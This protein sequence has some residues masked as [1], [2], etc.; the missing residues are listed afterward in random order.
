MAFIIG[1][2]NVLSFASYEDVVATDQRL[3]Q[4]NEG[5]TGDEGVELVE[6]DLFRATERIL[7]QIRATGWWVNYYSIQSGGSFDNPADVP[8]V[9]PNLIQDR[10]ADFTDLC[11]FEAL[12]YYI[13]PGVADFGDGDAGGDAAFEKIDYYKIKSGGLLDE[14]ILAGDWYD[15]DNDGIIQSSEKEPAI[16]L[17][18]TDTMTRIR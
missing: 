3:F 9:D 1:G 12:Y 6:D 7:T 14:L 11:V 13:L 18:D 10:E 5:L 16:R 17:I 8:E 15:F 4:A 2:G